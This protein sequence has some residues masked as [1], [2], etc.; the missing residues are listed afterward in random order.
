M[1]WVALCRDID[2]S[3]KCVLFNDYDVTKKLMN[4]IVVDVIVAMHC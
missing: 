3:L 4:K 1:I 2:N